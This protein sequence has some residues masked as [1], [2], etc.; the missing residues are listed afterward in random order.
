MLCTDHRRRS[1]VSKLVDRVE[2]HYECVR[3][4]GTVIEVEKE[5]NGLDISCKV[6]DIHVSNFSNK[7][8]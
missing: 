4:F 5:L 6:F 2:V 8:G 3:E 1:K 7:A